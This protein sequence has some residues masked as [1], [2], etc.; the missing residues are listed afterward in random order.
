MKKIVEIAKFI[1][2]KF[3]AVVSILLLLIAGNVLA[4]KVIEVNEERKGSVDQEQVMEDED[5]A[6]DSMEKS[7]DESET[8]SQEYLL[9]DLSEEETEAEQ[10]SDEVIMVEPL[11]YVSPD[12]GETAFEALQTL[13]EIEYDEYD[14]GVYIKSIG[15]VAGND[16]YFWAL[17]VN[18]EQA[19]AG[20]DQTNLE[21]GDKMEWRYEKII[22]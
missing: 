2:A 15:G 22:F 16:E 20:A 12:G 19:Q 1:Q 9:M 8:E 10:P 14:F 7:M 6:E 18:G 13:I 11:I 21:A 5:H 17:Y 4:A 3:V